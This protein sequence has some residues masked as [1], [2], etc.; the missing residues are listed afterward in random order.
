[1]AVA[2]RDGGTATLEAPKAVATPA[3]ADP[4]KS[5]KVTDD[6]MLGDTV[7]YVDNASQIAGA[8]N[9]THKAAMVSAILSD[10]ALFL[11]VFGRMGWEPVPHAWRDESESPQNRTWHRRPAKK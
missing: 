1:M 3:K 7:I 2:P 6:V 4:I 10:G 5:Q 9:P 8:I 11:H